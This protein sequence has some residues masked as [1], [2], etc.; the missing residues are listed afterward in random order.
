[1]SGVVSERLRQQ[2]LHQ[3]HY[4]AVA[5]YP[6]GAEMYCTLSREYYWPQMDNDVFSTKRNFQGCSQHRG[7]H[8]K[9]QKLEKLFPA[10]LSFESVTRFVPSLLKKTAR[11]VICTLVMT[12]LFIKLIRCISLQSYAQ[13]HIP[14][15][16]G[17]PVITSTAL[18]CTASLTAGNRSWRRSLALCTRYC[19]PR[20]ISPKHI[21]CRQTGISSGLARQLCR[22][23]GI[24]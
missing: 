9:H 13:S 3:A 7:T 5:G 18:F 23:S 16:S 8:F 20:T 6:G 22:D 4:P 12:D 14:L 17:S 11:L 10:T 21:I 1:M 19:A 2:A 15:L 24:T